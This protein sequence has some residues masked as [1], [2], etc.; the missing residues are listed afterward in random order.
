MYRLS[1]IEHST[2][3]NKYH[4][5]S[6]DLFDQLQGPSYFLKI[7]LSLGYHKLRVREVDIPK[8]E[9]RTRYDHF[10]FLVMSFCLTN[11]PAVFMDLMNRV[12]RKYLDLF[13]ILFIDDIFIY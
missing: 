4:L 1:S 7:Y 6:I 5:P 10:E 3:I 9:F 13:V 2:I 8:T 12:I 11:V